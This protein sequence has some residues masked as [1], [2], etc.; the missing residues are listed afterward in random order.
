MLHFEVE[1]EVVAADGGSDAA[2]DLCGT[3]TAEELCRAI[4]EQLRRSV[5]TL[6]LRGGQKPVGYE[7][8]IVIRDACEEV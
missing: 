7:L 6:L 4:A 5:E 3:F 8:R 1:A 2:Y